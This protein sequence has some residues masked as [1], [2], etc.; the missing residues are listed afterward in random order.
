LSR[1]INP[2]QYQVLSNFLALNGLT[3]YCCDPERKQFSGSVKC[4]VVEIPV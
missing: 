1:N 2:V 4:P 3:A